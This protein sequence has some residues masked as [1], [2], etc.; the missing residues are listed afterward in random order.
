[1]RPRTSSRH[2]PRRSAEQRRSAPESATSDAPAQLLDYLDRNAELPG[3]VTA[4]AAAVI[5]ASAL[6]R[7]LTSGQAHKIVA[8]L[9]PALRPLFEPS[10]AMRDR[11]P[12]AH[13]RRREFIEGIAEN[14][15][16]APVA[17]ELV[18]I[19]VFRALQDTLPDEE[20]GNVTRQLP[21]DLQ[22]LWLAGQPK[23]RAMAS[24]VTLHD[25]VFH[26]IE[27]A[28]V[29]P[30]HV[31]VPAA[32]STVMCLL[33]RRLSG[34][35]SRHLL[36]G[37]PRTLRSLVWPS[38]PNR[39]ESASTFGV[40]EFTAAVADDL[41]IDLDNAAEVINVVFAAARSVLPSEER[42]HVASQLPP[43]LRRLWNREEPGAGA[44]AEV[45]V[46]GREPFETDYEKLPVGHYS[47]RGTRQEGTGPSGPFLEGGPARFM[48]P[49]EQGGP[50]PVAPPLRRGERRSD[51]RILDDVEKRLAADP[52]LAEDEIEVRVSEGV[53]TLSGA[54]DQPGERVHADTLALEVPGV[55]KTVNLIHVLQPWHA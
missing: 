15:G 2:Q 6:F 17:A 10:L 42:H 4:A 40:P 50:E 12:L 18:T 11:E 53:V 51:E 21:R 32:F 36:L 26:K 34:G 41:R 44:V 19:T 39:G 8:A 1:M 52:E 31:G 9:P 27:D 43:D 54:V 16:L 25:E 37:L 48:R 46:T 14:L 35:E 38:L 29:L 45:L 33:A 7:R 13:L 3:H 20:A 30:P 55:E 22:E 28:E 24:E 47:G 49:P 5:V 23:S